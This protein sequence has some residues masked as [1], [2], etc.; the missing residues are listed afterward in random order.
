M[1][2]DELTQQTQQCTQDVLDPRREGRNNSGLSTED[3]SDVMCIFHPGTPAAYNLANF[4]AQRAPQ[5]I[6]EDVDL[7]EEEPLPAEATQDLDDDQKTFILPG[8]GDRPIQSYDFAFR[9]S[10]KTLQPAWGITFGRNPDWCDII[11]S[12]D[13]HKRVSNMHFA[14]YMNEA[15]VIMLQDTSTNGTMVDDV[16]LKSK[17][18][19]HPTARML[20]HG[21]VI[22]ILSPSPEE[23][24][25]FIVRIPSRTGFT[26]QYLAKFDAYLARQIEAETAYRKARGDETSPL[27]WR[28]TQN[29]GNSALRAPIVSDQYGM[30]WDGGIKFNVV[31]QIGKG[32]FASVYQ[33]ATKGE[34]HLYAAKELEKRRFMKNGIL[35]RKLENEM[36]IM[37]QINHKS[38]V[39]YHGYEDAP[40]HLYIIMEYVGRGDLQQHLAETGPLLEYTAKS[41]SIQVLDALDYL[42]KKN[43]T[44]RDIKPDNILLEERQPHNF[45]IKLSDFG[46]SKVVD[47]ND[48]FLKTF[49]GTLLYCAPE[50]FPHYDGPLSKGVKRPRA[51]PK[52]HSNKQHTYSQAVDI[53]SY[54]AVLWY[55]LCHKPPFEGIA[56]HTGRGMFDRIMMT[57]LDVS[58]LKKT[59]KSAVALLIQMLNTDP[60][61][62]P[63]AETCLKHEWFADQ[64][65]PVHRPQQAEVLGAIAEEPE[66]DATAGADPDVAALS[67]QEKPSSQYS[68]VSLNSSDMNFFDP[69]QSKRFKL[70][71][72]ENEEEELVDSSPELYDSIPIALQQNG[73]A[74]VDVQAETESKVKPKKL[75]GEISQSDLQ[76]TAYGQRANT[77][78]A[79]YSSSVYSEHVP[80]SEDSRG[81]ERSSSQDN[82]EMSPSLYGTESMVRGMNMDSAFGQTSDGVDP[83]TPSSFGESSD[84]DLSQKTPAG[85]APAPV[86]AN[87]PPP[88]SRQINVPLP[89]SYYWKANDP[90]THT[91]EYAEKVSGRSFA[92]E[93]MHLPRK[94]ASPPNV[95]RRDSASIQ[96]NLRQDDSQ[97]LATTN[98]LY[99]ASRPALGRLVTTHDSFAQITIDLN[100]RWTRWGRT[101]TNEVAFDDQ[102]E[103]R[104]PKT[105]FGVFWSAPELDQVPEDDDITGLPGLYCGILT[106]AS[107]GVHVNGVQLDKGE[108]G[109]QRFGRLHTGDII[110]IW[111]CASN[112]KDRL[113]FKCEF[114]AGAGKHRRTKDGPKFKVE[115][116]GRSRSTSQSTQ[117]KKE[118][119]AAGAANAQTGEEEKDDDELF[120]YQDEAIFGDCESEIVDSF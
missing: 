102:M 62:R 42:H 17:T 92:A 30:H 5:Y 99:E 28:T 56:D 86:A 13:V 26:D 59:S 61:T 35:D 53:W 69:R 80:E 24:I 112:K 40:N 81:G 111:P 87:Q 83:K 67:I 18:G 108:P 2:S 120:P 58:M 101:P 49:C 3:I 50:V 89:P 12:G 10:T 94:L 31:A 107:N 44:H 114:Y 9:F 55:S 7:S 117:D 65:P 90:S 72:D 15:G 105:A 98:E 76:H 46:L 11:V 34:G 14:L 29:A 51:P 110:D 25:K 39:A 48:T 63:S 100:K 116:E 73:Q 45:I 77:T 54:G 23:A 93:K 20:N 27:K 16:L 19:Q 95:A 88:F 6:L 96:S 118:A 74:Q 52:Q 97:R 57:P 104:V 41:M 1:D 91:I 70:D 47:T 21:S 119:A 109:R 22:Q 60:S 85:N 33:L 79:N 8:R 38:I 115:R 106:F 36:N 84:A 71:H 78:Q 32:A 113:R 75:F 64:P 37:R 66:A 82:R 68:E 43:I 4:T 103:L